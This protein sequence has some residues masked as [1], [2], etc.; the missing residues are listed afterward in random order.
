MLSAS[1]SLRSHADSRQRWSLPRQT[2]AALQGGA[3]SRFR[4][5]LPARN[6]VPGPRTGSPRNL[7][8]Q[9]RFWA[10][11]E[12]EARPSVAA[13]HLGIAGALAVRVAALSQGYSSTT[14]L[15]K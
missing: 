14:S 2:N 5:S 6:R 9:L 4:P 11:L 8:S 1:N 10:A 12:R 3:G 7:D 13:Q 15:T